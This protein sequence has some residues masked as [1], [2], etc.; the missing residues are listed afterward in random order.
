MSNWKHD[1]FVISTDKEKLDIDV[2]YTFLSTE[3]ETRRD[4]MVRR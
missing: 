4:E 3:S 1:N 2:I